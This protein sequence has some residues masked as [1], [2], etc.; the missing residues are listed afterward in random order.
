MLLAI[1]ISIVSYCTT[2]SIKIPEK[3]TFWSI[4]QTSQTNPLLIIFMHPDLAWLVGE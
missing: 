2:N 3:K 1:S 4:N